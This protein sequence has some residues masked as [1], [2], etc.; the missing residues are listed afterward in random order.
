MRRAVVLACLAGA[1]LLAGALPASTQE[2]TTVE[3]KDNVFAPATITVPAGATIT[4]KNTGAAPH[5]GT[6]KDKSFDTG[7]INPGESKTVTVKTS[8]DL[9]CTLHETIGMVGRVEVQGGG[10]AAGASP[11][12]AASPSPAASPTSAAKKGGPTT[13]RPP[14]QKYFPALAGAL[15]GLLVLGTGLGYLRAQK[16]ISGK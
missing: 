9:V 16:R 2:T 14:T 5:T 15:F 6:A 8:V 10:A 1:I 11:T 3:T 4:F 7:I 12:A 13:E